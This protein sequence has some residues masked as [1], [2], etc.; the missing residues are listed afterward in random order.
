MV[1]ELFTVEGQFQPEPSSEN[2][3]I[4]EGDIVFTGVD[5]EE[6]EDVPPGAPI[7]QGL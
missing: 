3:A 5:L 4:S 6:N 7:G 2:E 1:A